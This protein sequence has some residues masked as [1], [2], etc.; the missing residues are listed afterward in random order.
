MSR[1]VFVAGFGLSVL[2][3][4]VWVG[5]GISPQ[6]RPTVLS[7]FDGV[8]VSLPVSLKITGL[9]FTLLNL[10]ATLAAAGLVSLED[11]Q[12]FTPATRAVSMAILCTTFSAAWWWL[13]ARW[14]A[15]KRVS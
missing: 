5:Y 1:S 15:G 14:N 11:L 6:W 2:L 12:R 3:L 4:L 8:Y 10:P 13:L 7:N 9:L